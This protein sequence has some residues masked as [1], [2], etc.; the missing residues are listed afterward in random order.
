MWN[1][2][3]LS[4]SQNQHYYSCIYMYFKLM[5]KKYIYNSCSQVNGYDRYMYID[6]CT[7]SSR[8]LTDAHYSC[9]QLSSVEIGTV[10]MY[11]KKLHILQ[12]IYM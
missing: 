8:Y 3:V 2:K 6:I 10:Y 4:W 9:V 12:I 1:K 11:V 5:Y 7:Q